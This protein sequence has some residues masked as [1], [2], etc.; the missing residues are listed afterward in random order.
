MDLP[1]GFIIAKNFYLFRQKTL[2]GSKFEPPRCS[3]PPIRKF[4]DVFDCSGRW[5]PRLLPADQLPPH[6]G[7]GQKEINILTASIAMLSGVLTTPDPEH[8]GQSR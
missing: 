5:P 3:P 2:P 6:L 7:D 1:T 8:P 4:R